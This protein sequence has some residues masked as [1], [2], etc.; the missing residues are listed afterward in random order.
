M[1]NAK[2]I[3]AGIGPGSREDMT[4]AVADAVREA[5][6]IIG[7]KYYFQ[8]VEPWLRPGTECVDTGMKKERE[9]GGTSILLL[10]FSSLSLPSDALVK[11][12]YP[13]FV[14]DS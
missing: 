13:L 5:D 14:P 7:Y 11:R 1:S 9:R 8:F 6:S 2:I 4:P 3:V 12:T 10:N